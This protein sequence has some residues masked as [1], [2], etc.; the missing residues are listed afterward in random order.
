VVATAALA[1]VLAGCSVSSRDVVDEAQARGGGLSGELVA[2]AAGAV[3]EDQGVDAAALRSVTVAFTRVVLEVGVPADDPDDTA[4]AADD[5]DLDAEVPEGGLAGVAGVEEVVVYEYGTSGRFGGNG[6]TGPRD[7]AL[8]ITGEPLGPSLFTLAQAGAERFDDMVATALR[9]AG[10]DG[11]YA[12][13]ATIARPA[14]GGDPQTVI[15]VTNGGGGGESGD[16]VRVTLGPDG[17]VL[18]VVA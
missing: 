8:S 15:I 13:G 9:E 16:G 1:V 4:D 17:R 3:A 2:V 11:G 12:A 10:L 18:E 6:L 5:F 7:V 14:G